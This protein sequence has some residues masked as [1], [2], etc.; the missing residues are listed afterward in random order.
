MTIADKSF[1][2]KMMV[3]LLEQYLKHAKDACVY[4]GG[5]EERDGCEEVVKELSS[6]IA[7]TNGELQTHSSFDFKK[8]IE[9]IA[10][11][12]QYQI[13]K[14]YNARHDDTHKNGELSLY[15][16][17]VLDALRNSKKIDSGYDAQQDVSSL[18]N[19]VKYWNSTE[20]S[21]AIAASLIIA[22]LERRRRLE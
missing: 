21:L 9:E 17:Y 3:T 11:I 16:L 18:I 14:E 19:D 5:G 15:A 10:A 6:L 4:Y 13:E 1:K 7:K 12:R 20:E 2:H 8:V 22:D